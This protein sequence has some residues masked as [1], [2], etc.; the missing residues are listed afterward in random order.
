MK[1]KK[2]VFIK[3]I[4]FIVVGIW[5]FMGNALVLTSMFFTGQDTG[6]LYSEVTDYMRIVLIP[7]AFWMS[8]GLLLIVLGICSMLFY[9]R[10]RLYQSVI[11]QRPFVELEELAEETDY[12]RPLVKRDISKMIHRDYFPF[13]VL[14]AQKRSLILDKNIYEEYLVQ[15]ERWEKANA[16]AIWR[17]NQMRLAGISE[18]DISSFESAMES[19]NHIKQYIADIPD[20]SE[21]GRI[22]D[23]IDKMD[24]ILA[25]TIDR[26]KQITQIEK[27]C[28]LYIPQFEQ[29]TGKYARVLQVEENTPMSTEFQEFLIHLN[30]TLKTDYL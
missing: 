10:I 25:Q 27:L 16:K 15:W 13:A 28:R 17:K 22:T 21:K 2:R 5:M 20:K 30:H 19:V 12:N 29:L 11:G 3:N 6:I 9:R 24:R 23:I 8:L 26:P 7:V 1:M 4:L 14:D 18:Q